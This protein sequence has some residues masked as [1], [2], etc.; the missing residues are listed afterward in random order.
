MLGQFLYHN[1]CVSVTVSVSVSVSEREREC[2]HVVVIECVCV[3]VCVCVCAR[4]C[5]SV[6][7]A[8]VRAYVRECVFYRCETAPTL[9]RL[10]LYLLSR[11]QGD[12][13]I[14]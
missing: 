10:A 2:D 3:C 8:C 4:E 9:E 13:P 5:V 7:A 12:L 14:D 6:C 11:Q 1:R